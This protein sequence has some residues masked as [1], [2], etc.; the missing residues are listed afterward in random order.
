MV[1]NKDS[2]FYKDQYYGG[3]LYIKDSFY[4]PVKEEE[5]DMLRVVVQI[6]RGIDLS[7]INKV[8]NLIVYFEEEEVFREDLFIDKVV[9]NDKSFFTK[10]RDFFLK[11]F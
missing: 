2:F 9:N 3:E 10:V 4:Y 1:V 5:K 6:I 11:I 7:K 8:G